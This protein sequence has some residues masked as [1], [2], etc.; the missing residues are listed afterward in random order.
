MCQSKDSQSLGKGLYGLCPEEGCCTGVSPRSA[1]VEQGDNNT[2][3][4]SIRP[5]EKCS[6]F[7]SILFFSLL[8]M[9]SYVEKNIEFS[10]YQCYPQSR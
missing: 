10:L 7:F 3:L 8:D 1:I 2:L 6:T 5:D 9:K 4:D